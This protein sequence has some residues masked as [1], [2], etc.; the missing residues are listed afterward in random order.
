MR[1][2]SPVA[3]TASEEKKEILQKQIDELKKSESFFRAITQNS[4]DIVIIVNKKAIITY[5]NPAIERLMGYS[6]SELL[7]QSAFDFIDPSDLPRA[8][9]DFGRAILT[10]NININ[11]AFGV[12]H[13][14][15]SIRILE[16][17]GVNLFRNR[18]VGGFVMNVR[19]VTDRRRAEDELAAYRIKLEQRVRERT[20]ELSS[21]NQQL[22]EEL[23]RHRLTQAALKESEEKY[24]D[25]LE[26]APIGVG[27][28]DLEGKVQYINRR[29][30]TMMGWNREDI[31]G[32]YG[33]G[34]DVFD[35]ATRC[36][37]LERFSAR[38]SGD[39]AQMLEIPIVAKDGGRLWVEVITTIL[40]KHDRPVGAQ[41]VFVDITKRKQAQEEGSALA[42]R[43]HRAE[44]MESLGT[45]AGGVAHDLNN[46]LG[47]LV[48]YTELLLMKMNDD[49]PLKKHLHSIMKSSEKATAIIQD[50][51]T[52][53]RRGVTVSQVVH[54][55]DILVEYFTAPEF[56][57]LCA[58]HP[59]VS[60]HKDF[61]A[62][63]LN[64]KGSPVHLGK[65]AMNLISNAVEAIENQGN[66]VVRTWNC[67]LERPCSG[68][69]DVKEGDY[70]CLTVQDT[71]LGIDPA[72][73][74]KI[75]EPFYTKKVMGR[76]GTGLGLAVVWGT[77]VDHQGYIDVQ[78]APGRGSAFTVY[79]PATRESRPA[80]ESVMSLDSYMGRG[81]SVLIVDDV[82]E[83]REIATRLLERLGYQARSV[84]SGEEAVA[85][86]KNQPF[87]ILVLDMLMEPGIDGLET[88]R[89]VLDVSPGQKAVIVSGFSQTERVR[90][91]L[92]L[93]A[94]DY[95]RKP[96]IMETIGI[97]LRK[98]LCRK[99]DNS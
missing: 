26:N 62:D 63:L 99:Q 36:K 54:L 67:Y 13:K 78:S 32:R 33:F 64:I 43:L 4:S 30:E 90:E 94:G 23:D 96:Y 87:D 53:A 28:I 7:G 45:L 22:I 77:V 57:R 56:K 49:D 58:Y 44:K 61:S 42:A 9:F 72:D 88:Y 2:K 19:D 98:T 14:D 25:F 8:L 37:L 15:G 40:K 39:P 80:H 47:V 91:A 29:I 16:G 46:V 1:K 82:P 74:E 18:A 48:G 50:M 79:F 38:L 84:S 6:P 65:A 93:G 68:Y 52:L 97:A 35:E 21:A 55:N 85:F 86:L 66:V 75:F 31:V 81:E 69:T 92:R 73:R 70:V 12:R 95:V 20:V 89:R 83:Q 51:L 5:V 27:M 71:G 11:N 41:M 17:I 60:I 24:R 76:S 34:L 10:K 59:Q 3:S